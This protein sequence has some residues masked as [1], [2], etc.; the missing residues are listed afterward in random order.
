MRKLFSTLRSKLSEAKVCYIRRSRSPQKYKTLDFLCGYLGDESFVL[1]DSAKARGKRVISHV[2]TIIS[3]YFPKNCA[4]L[5]Y[6]NPFFQPDADLEKDA[7]EA[8]KK[9]ATVLIT[10]KQYKDYP[11]II[12]DDPLAVYSK[13]CRYYRDLQNNVSITAVT[14]SIGK[15]T[16]SSMISKVYKAGGE[17][18]YAEVN[19]NSLK[20]IG[21]AAQH[22]PDKAVFMVQEFAESDPGEI[23]YYSLMMHPDVFVI[24]SIDNSHFE[25]FG[26]VEKITEEI[27]SVTNNMSPDGVVIVNKDEFT[28]YDLLSGRRV[29]TIS[30]QDID[31]DFHAENIKVGENGLSFDVLV[32]EDGKRYPVFLNRIYALHNVGCALYAFAAGWQEG[33]S[34]DRIISGLANY[35]TCGIRQNVLKTN[36]GIVV[37]LDCYNAVGRSVKSAIDACDSMPVKGK[38]V[39]VLGDI[40][41]VGDLSES[42]HKD[43]VDY[44]NESKFDVLLTLGD[45]LMKAVESS[46]IRESLTVR[47]FN[48]REDLTAALK[49]IINEQ[50]LVLFKSSHSFRLDKCARSIWPEL[51]AGM[52]MPS[53]NEWIHRSLYW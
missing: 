51:E 1:S 6:T 12:C 9:G 45:C 33:I 50:D 32:K 49:E 4:C 5:V 22:I 26:S 44:V 36:D 14:G 11:C 23:Q 42:M 38:R 2:C 47:C 29:S 48:I 27:C 39:A 25:N 16:V 8:I 37:Y 35:R 31:S 20:S 34:P 21:F 30:Y 24:T 52:T 3:K 18:V 43:I 7:D 41:E 53:H 46:T 17:T 40:K 28:R 10:D 15:T 13:L 19:A